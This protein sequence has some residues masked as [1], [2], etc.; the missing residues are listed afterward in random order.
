[1]VIERT[2][3]LEAANTKLQSEIAERKRMDLELRK[4]KDELEQKVL[5]RTEDL[6]K[7]NERLQVEIMEHQKAREAAEAAAEAKAAFLANMSHELRTPMNYILGIANLLLDEPL[8]PEQ[9]EYVE[10]IK[11]GG[12]G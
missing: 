1:M 3:K 5:E 10:I 9:K 4:S 12:T 7:A 8:P 6:T 2:F 11:E